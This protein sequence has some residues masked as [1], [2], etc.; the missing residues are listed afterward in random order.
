M[1]GILTFGVFAVQTQRPPTQ[2]A[3]IF[4]GG[5]EAA[6][7]ASLVSRF[8][9]RGTAPGWL[10][11]DNETFVYTSPKHVTYIFLPSLH[12]IF[13]YRALQFFRQRLEK[14][15]LNVRVT[16]GEL[17]TFMQ[18]QLSTTLSRFDFQPDSMLNLA[19]DAVAKV[20]SMGRKLNFHQLLMGKSGERSSPHRD[21]DMK[22]I[23]EKKDAPER[24]TDRVLI[25]EYQVFSVG[26]TAENNRADL[27]QD[28]LTEFS[29][30]IARRSDEEKR[31]LVNLFKDHEPYLSMS[32]KI[33]QGFNTN[34]DRQSDPAGYSLSYGFKLMMNQLGFD[35]PK[36]REEF[37]QQ[38]KIESLTLGFRIE[39]VTIMNG[40]RVVSSVRCSP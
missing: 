2:S 9:K 19:T 38:A 29:K 35:E 32:T 27:V 22:P 28:A 40:S 34:A 17:P 18:T 23:A 4:A 13:E 3:L 36:D 1:L 33:G 11:I 21:E 25:P 26:L 5:R 39:F 24:P 14:D 7:K 12:E 37:I 30:E 15:G 6:P 8:V 16:F 10:L 20:S 31:S